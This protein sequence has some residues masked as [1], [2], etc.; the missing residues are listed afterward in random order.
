MEGSKPRSSDHRAA[1]QAT[2]RG[3]QHRR[4]EQT[5]RTNTATAARY[6]GQARAHHRAQQARTEQHRDNATAARAT[7]GARRGGAGDVLGRRSRDAAGGFGGYAYAYVRQA[8][9]FSQYTNIYGWLGQAIGIRPYNQTV[10]TQTRLQRWWGTDTTTTAYQAG[11]WT[12]FALDIA[13]AGRGSVS[14]AKVTA[15]PVS[16]ATNTGVGV[17]RVV[18]AVPDPKPAFRPNGAPDRSSPWYVSY[19]DAGGNVQTVGN[20]DGVHAEVRIQQ[21]LPGAPMSRPFGWRTLDSGVG[22]QW[23]EGTVCQG[24]QV[25]PRT[26][27]PPGTRGA[28]GGPWGD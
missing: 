25:L 4:A 11:G 10:R 1:T 8:A 23:V 13:A 12:A 19:R 16:L 9:W 3:V 21:M 24:C 20:L 18:D 17:S 14:V 6:T 26:L 2:N 28:P 5:R 22:P 7:A 27:F 15:R